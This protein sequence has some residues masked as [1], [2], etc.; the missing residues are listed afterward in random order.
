[1][2]LGKPKFIQELNKQGRVVLCWSNQNVQV[3]RVTWPTV[4]GQAVRPDNEKINAAGV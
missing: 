3:A 2:R 1:M 4:K